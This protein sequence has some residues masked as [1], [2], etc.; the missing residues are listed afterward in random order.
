MPNSDLEIKSCE[1]IAPVSGDCD[2]ASPSSANLTFAQPL[3]PGSNIPL[4]EIRVGKR[5]PVCIDLSVR[6]QREATIASFSRACAQ[7]RKG[8]WKVRGSVCSMRVGESF[9]A[10]ALVYV[11]V[12]RPSR[13]KAYS[14]DPSTY[15]GAWGMAD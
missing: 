3:H 9:K 2:L 7:W 8:V 12:M 15:C 10:R 14:L 1:S 5:A 6:N 11:V 13:I 4:L